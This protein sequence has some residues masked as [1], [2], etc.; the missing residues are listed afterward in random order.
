[1]KYQFIAAH[2]REYPVKTM[3]RILEVAVSGYFAWLRRLGAPSR[4][5]QANAGLGERM[6]RIY[7]A[8]RQVYGS[9]R[10]HA[11]LRARSGAL[12]AQASGTTHAR[13]RAERQTTHASRPHDR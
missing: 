12:R 6:V 11:V 8:N 5:S 1:M 13:A 4:R 7:Q 9:P 10:I 3:C 2:Q